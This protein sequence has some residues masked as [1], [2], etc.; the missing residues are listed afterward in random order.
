MTFRPLPTELLKVFLLTPCDRSF[1]LNPSLQGTVKQWDSVH[2]KRDKKHHNTV[3]DPK[4]RNTPRERSDSRGR[5]R[6]GRGG[7]RGSRGGA[8][9]RGG[10]NGYRVQALSRNEP[11][12]LT[13]SGTDNADPT[14]TV[15]RD[16]NVTSTSGWG[17]DQ[18][19]VEQTH[20]SSFQ[21]AGTRLGESPPVWG[22]DPKPNGT[23]SP[24]VQVKSLAPVPGLQKPASKNPATSGLSWAEVA[25][26]TPS[27][28]ISCLH[29]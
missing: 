11:V 9:G 13:M 19:A 12:D 4:D 3:Q 2:R 10:Q 5:G 26:Y 18:T 16:E 15:S 28:Q 17:P 14:T 20:D 21:T 1:S 24:A 22:V 29:S 7:G 23:P 8:P 27:T 6:G 25:R